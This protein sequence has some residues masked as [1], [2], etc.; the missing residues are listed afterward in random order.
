MRWRRIR[1][2][3]REIGDNG[4]LVEISSCWVGAFDRFGDAHGV[5]IAAD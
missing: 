4:G 3:C 5:S 1:S 2:C